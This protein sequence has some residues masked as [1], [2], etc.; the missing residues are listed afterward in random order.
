M[1]DP[2]DAFR[3]AIHERL[4]YAPDH[5]EPG[6][7]HRFP[8]CGR[9]SDLAGWCKLFDDE[10]AGVFGDYRQGIS[11]TWSAVERH[12]LTVAEHA[13]IDAR[14]VA[15]RAER[16]AQQQE[17]WAV[18]A[19]RIAKTWDESRPLVPGDPATLYLKRRGLA[20]FWP[21]PGCLR[22]HRGLAYWHEGQ[23][24]GTFPVMVASLAAP[25][26]RMVALHRTYLTADGRKAN[27]PQVK[28]LSGTAGPL[29]GACVPLH[30]PVHGG[31]GIAEGIE[32]ALAASAG[33]GVPIVAAYSAGNLSTWRWPEGLQRLVIFGD[34]DKA[35]RD[36]AAELHARAVRAGLRCEVLTP[37]T[38]GED[39]CD[40]WAAR[41]SIPATGVHA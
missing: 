38:E 4:G 25:D 35:G 5:I 23:Q 31:L 26:G 30:A 12:R 16:Q 8:T 28:K 11:E 34:A 39:W 27:V 29:T 17:Q 33:S 21:L 22:L 3:D 19:K 9:R 37:S 18:N 24:L 15:A 2:I 40:V 32:T 7:L 20:G 36:A 1:A 13:A 6:K 10:R 14:I 41:R